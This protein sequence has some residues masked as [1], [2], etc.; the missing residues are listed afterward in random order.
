MHCIEHGTLIEPDT[1][2]RSYRVR[3]G[4]RWRDVIKAL[5]PLGFSP[6]VTQSNHDFSVGGT[7]SVNA[8]GWPVPYGPFGTTV[9]SFRLM[10]ADGSVVTCSRDENAELFRHAIGGYGLFGIVIDAEL[11]MADNVLLRADHAVMPAA[12]F[13][14]RF[15]AV[16]RATDVRMAYGRLAVG[17]DNF[18][19]EA[20]LSSFRPATTQPRPLPA[21]E[22]SQ[23]FRLLS[24][25]VFRAQIGSERAKQRR[26]LVLKMM[27][28]IYLGQSPLPK[29]LLDE[30]ELG[31]VA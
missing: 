23:A 1:A 6:M 22:T 27:R 31:L 9:R 25:K 10:L 29:T 2:R 7:L 28:E 15:T 30:V 13:A 14:A 5:D 8:H 16:A 11:D 24:R 26:N 4:A 19:A 12:Q 18:L 20:L 3:A 21:P 17:R